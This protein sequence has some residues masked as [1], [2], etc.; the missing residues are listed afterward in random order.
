MKKKDLPL[1]ILIFLVIGFVFST[2]YSKS[3]DSNYSLVEINKNVISNKENFTKIMSVLTHERCMNCH[4]NDNI[5][6]QGDD[7]HPHYFGMM[8]GKDDHGF[9][10]TKCSTCHQAENNKYSGVPGAPHWRL[11]PASMGWQGLTHKEIA[12]SLIDKSK[13]G[14]RSHEDLVRHLTEDKLVLWAWE[15]GVDAEGNTRKVPPVSK[16]EFGTAVKQWFEDGAIIPEE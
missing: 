9:E 15:P 2:S 5:P 12:Q 13:N 1:L 8:R 6:K 7:G 10:A 4:P 16:E 14:N 3:I 11:A